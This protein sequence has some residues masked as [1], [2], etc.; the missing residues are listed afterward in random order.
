MGTREL[1]FPS[2]I[3]F[4]K[5]IP[6]ASIRV[7]S[8][9]DVSKDI[10]MSVTHGSS[11]DPGRSTNSDPEADYDIEAYGKQ[12]HVGLYSPYYSPLEAKRQVNTLLQMEELEEMSEEDR[13]GYWR[14]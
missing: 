2:G 3:A 13:L 4:G 7:R 6:I 8:G 5:S 14:G 12:E 11:Q 10:D 9:R 1:K